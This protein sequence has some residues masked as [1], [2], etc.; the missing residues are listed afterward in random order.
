MWKDGC[1]TSTKGGFGG[2]ILVSAYA[3]EKHRTNIEKWVCG[4]IPGGGGSHSMGKW[5]MGGMW[6]LMGDL[7]A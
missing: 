2:K 4:G 1:T 5:T 6:Q 3:K 7:W